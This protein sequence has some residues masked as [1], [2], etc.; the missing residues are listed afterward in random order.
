MWNIQKP[1]G[2][3]VSS[4]PRSPATESTMYWTTI[5]T[6]HTYHFGS[7]ISIGILCVVFFSCSLRIRFFCVF[8]RNALTLILSLISCINCGCCCYC[9]CS[10][11]W[12]HLA[13]KCYCMFAKK[14][15]FKIRIFS[16]AKKIVPQLSCIWTTEKYEMK[17]KNN[18]VLLKIRRCVIL[19]LFH[20]LVF[21]C[22]F[23]FF[24][25]ILYYFF[26]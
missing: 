8:A 11:P 19:N 7:S 14:K 5:T 2:G 24:I 3:L 10:L 16:F 25:H 17:K 13:S 9:G 22:Q 20:N 21:N 1:L 15:P 26:D 4:M 6:Q 23:G 18:I 12:N